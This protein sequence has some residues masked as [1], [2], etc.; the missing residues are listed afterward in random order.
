[1]FSGVIMDC[2]IWGFVR[3]A[4]IY[5]FAY[6]IY[7]SMGL[8]LIIYSIKAGLESIYYTIG[9]FIISCIIAGFIYGIPPIPL[10]PPPA[11]IFGKPPIPIPPKPPIPPIPGNPPIPIPGKPPAIGLG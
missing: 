6:T 2:N 10:G 5:G 7:E 8:L 9:L 1:M 3:I 11:A 4:L